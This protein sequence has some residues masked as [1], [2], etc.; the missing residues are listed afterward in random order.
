MLA[1]KIL[2]SIHDAASYLE[3]ICRVRIRVRFFRSCP[4][5]PLARCREMRVKD[6]HTHARTHAHTRDDYRM[7]R[8][9]ARRGIMRGGQGAG[10]L[11][12]ETTCI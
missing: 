9:S 12:H 1:A 4:V 10:A 3:L 11:A 8:G 5:Y 2:N 6:T 7:P